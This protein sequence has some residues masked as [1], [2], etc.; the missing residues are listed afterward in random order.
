MINT[1]PDYIKASSS[2]EISPLTSRRDLKPT[3][4]DQANSVPQIQEIIVQ[5]VSTP[6]KST[7][8]TP[9]SKSLIEIFAKTFESSNQKNS[10]LITRQ[11]K[12]C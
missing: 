4:Q 5:V 6:D 3:S 11:K 10:V 7:R 2:K 12:N 1:S 8:P 9:R